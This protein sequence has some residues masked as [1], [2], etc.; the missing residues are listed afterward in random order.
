MVGTTA[1]VTFA[2]LSDHMVAVQPDSDLVHGWHG[3]PRPPDWQEANGWSGR[4]RC[5]GTLTPTPLSNAPTTSS[6][7]SPAG[8][9]QC[10]LADAGG[11][12]RC[13]AVRPYWEA[14]V[15][16]IALVQIGGEAQDL[17]SAKVAEPLLAALWAASN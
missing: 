5:A 13:D 8:G 11:F 12:R 9:R 2:K 6:V 16:H 4:Y 14:G 3:S 17:F 15:T 1:V 10:R 7:G